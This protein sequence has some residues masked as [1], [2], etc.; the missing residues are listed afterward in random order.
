MSSREQPT[1]RS[2]SKIYLVTPLIADAAEVARALAAALAAA[3]VAAVLA[4]LAPSDERTMI[5][6]LKQLAPTVQAGGAAL[7]V[8]GH[9][10]LVARAGADG[11]HLTGIAAFNAALPSLK[12]ER[13]A[14]CGGLNS[15]HDAMLAGE[16]GADYVMFGEPDGN[17]RRPSLDAIEERIAWWAEIFQPPCVGYAGA[18]EEVSVLA[19][20][21]ADFVALGDWLWSH[22]DGPA[23]AIA[24]AR[25]SLGME[26]VA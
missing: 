1:D 20:A 12:P 23:A 2:A 26:M 14:G 25:N 15:R 5:N 6:R 17:G 11:A 18:P 19:A 22:P 10:D 9:A 8:D 16:A 13:I 24:A 4:R 3:P 21:G 7:I